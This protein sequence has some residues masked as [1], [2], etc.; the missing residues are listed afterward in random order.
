LTRYSPRLL[1]SVGSPYFG[2]FFL[3]SRGVQA[4]P[5]P[6]IISLRFS[7]LFAGSAPPLPPKTSTLLFYRSSPFHLNWRVPFDCSL[8]PAPNSHSLLFMFVTGGDP[9]EL[10]V[11]CYQ[12]SSHL[13]IHDARSCFCLTRASAQLQVGSASHDS[14]LSC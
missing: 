8:V 6:P 4:R 3:S 7:S 10:R 12:Y 1:L 5:P 9:L 2:A 13:T 14:L 11:Y